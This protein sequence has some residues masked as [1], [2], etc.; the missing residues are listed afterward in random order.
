VNDA[1]I[2]TQ[3]LIPVEVFKDL[4]RCNKELLELAEDL[5]IQHHATL[6][7]TVHH[8]SCIKDLQD[9]HSRLGRSA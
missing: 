2:V 3:V 5:T 6:G 7:N 9:L 4:L 8:E 1:P